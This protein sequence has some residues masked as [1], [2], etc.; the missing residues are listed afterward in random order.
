MFACFV[1]DVETSL[2]CISKRFKLIQGLIGRGFFYFLYI[3]F[4]I[5]TL[6]IRSN[7]ILQ[8]IT[9]VLFMLMGLFYIFTTC[10]SNKGEE[11]E[12]DQELN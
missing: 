2:N 6:C 9:A 12:K 7:S 8:I 1:L 3:L 11:G 10:C 5:G 4:S